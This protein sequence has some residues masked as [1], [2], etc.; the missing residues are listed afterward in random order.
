MEEINIYCDESCHLEHDQSNVMS[1]GGVWLKKDKRKE[2]CERIKEIK[3]LNDIPID[4]ELKW[5]NISKMKKR[6]YFDLINMFFDDDDLH[7]RSVIVTDKSKL[8]FDLFTGD[9]DDWYYK[10]YYLMISQILSPDNKYNV[11]LD[12]K[13]TNSSKKLKVLKSAISHK[14]KN[15]Y[16][17]NRIQVIRSEEVEIMQ[18]TDILIGSLTYFNR[19][20]TDGSKTKRE[21][22]ELI[23]GH[24]GS[25]LEY[26]SLLR[27]DKFNIFYWEAR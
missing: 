1:I 8:N 19:N 24:S 9:Y 5:S 4:Y 18:L 26:S 21:I 12:I 25:T 23:R 17:I 10:I 6:V 3:R 14:T 15:D 16:I 2:V 22:I 7:F 20:F 11:Y 13:D 27:D